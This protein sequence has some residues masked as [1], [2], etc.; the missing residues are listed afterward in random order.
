MPTMNISITDLMRAWVQ[1]QVESGQYA[2]NSDYVRDLIRRD[3]ERAKRIEAMQAAIAKGL[4]S[5]EATDFDIDAFKQ[6]M[7][8]NF[9]DETL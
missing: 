8:N 4:E 3:Q 2:G 5:G 7:L 9:N 1:E 6:R